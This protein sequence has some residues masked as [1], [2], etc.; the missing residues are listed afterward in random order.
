MDKDKNNAG[1]SLHEATKNELENAHVLDEERTRQIEQ[2]CEGAESEVNERISSLERQE[3]RA[4][5]ELERWMLRN[6]ELEK[7]LYDSGVER[8][9]LAGLLR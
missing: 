8:T 9:E 3:A 2:I 5:E 4:R 1:V 7:R 6:E